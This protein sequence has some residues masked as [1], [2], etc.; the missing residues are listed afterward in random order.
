ML[1]DHDVEAELVGEHPLVVVAVEQ[2]GRDLGV[3]FA[4][5][6]VDAQRA[7]VVLPRLRIGLLGELVD[8]H[9]LSS[10][11]LVTLT[12]PHLAHGAHSEQRPETRRAHAPVEC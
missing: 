1:V 10:T 8:F 11:D 4:V 9:S 3:A 2:I 5:R 7:G 12:W 6:Q